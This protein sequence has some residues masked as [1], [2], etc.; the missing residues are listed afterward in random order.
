MHQ[1]PNTTGQAAEATSD[2]IPVRCRPYLHYDSEYKVLLCVK[3]DVPHAVTLANLVRHWRKD[4]KLKKQQYKPILDGIVT[5]TVGD[6]IDTLPRV[7]DG[8]PAR[9]RLPILEGFKCTFGDCNFRTAGFQCM[10][11]HSAIEHKY[12]ASRG[13]KSVSLQTWQGARGRGYWIVAG[14]HDE[15]RS[16]TPST[17]DW[18]ERVAGMESVRQRQR[19]E[20]LD[21]L[22]RGQVEI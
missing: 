21:I 1:E 7:P 2:S 14:E 17:G 5:L 12:E 4:Y 10:K 11:R 22:T 6:R 19:D 15:D 16:P 18:V 8:L 3:C 13:Y 20:R 9:P